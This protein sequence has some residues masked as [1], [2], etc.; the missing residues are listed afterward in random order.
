M[1]FCCG[2]YYIIFKN[3]RLFVECTGLAFT[4]LPGEVK[5]RILSFCSAQSILVL[6]VASRDCWNTIGRSD[7]VWE[8]AFKNQWPRLTRR[9]KSVDQE[10]LWEQSTVEP[11]SASSMG[12]PLSVSQVGS[13][14][15]EFT[16]DDQTSSS[17]CVPISCNSWLQSF[18]ER[19]ISTGGK[20]EDNRTEDWADFDFAFSSTA[21]KLR[22]ERFLKEAEERNR[23]LQ[24]FIDK[25]VPQEC[26]C[27]LMGRLS[28]I[29][30]I[31]RL[32]PHL[33]VCQRTG[34]SHYCT[35]SAGEEP[36]SLSVENYGGNYTCQLSGIS[37]IF[38]SEADVNPP[39]DDE[40]DMLISDYMNEDLE[41]KQFLEREY[42][43]GYCMNDEEA[44][45]YFGKEIVRSTFLENPNLIKQQRKRRKLV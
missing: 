27:T 12:S 40:F 29:C 31:G 37:A 7:G 21:A 28:E 2:Y 16:L 30:W 41:P 11:S 45:A 6:N 35:L 3:S 33:Y 36:C 39:A 24:D 4:D 20:P 1:D 43:R 9:N 42:E 26:E 19:W 32:M 18:K 8:V 23:S 15:S 10:R 34:M 17:S 38:A 44:S 13:P 25:L 22:Q 14:M 5:C